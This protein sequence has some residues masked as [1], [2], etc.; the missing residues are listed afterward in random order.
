MLLVLLFSFIWITAL[1]G[2]ELSAPIG[3]TSVPV[4]TETVSVDV[5]VAET[6]PEGVSK[7]P[8]RLPVPP[9]PTTMTSWAIPRTVRFSRPVMS[10]RRVPFRNTDPS[11]VELNRYS[12]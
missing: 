1:T 6:F 5:P 7:V 8:S 4:A 12:Q 2:I 10:A 9:V 11:K 3:G